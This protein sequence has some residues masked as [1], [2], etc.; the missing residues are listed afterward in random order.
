MKLAWVE[1]FVALVDARTFSRAAMLRNV[2]QPA[3][4]RRIRML[5]DW[6]GVKLVSR[7]TH[8]LRLTDTATRYEPAL[9]RLVNRCHEL[10]GQM[11]AD[12]LAGQRIALVTQHTLMVTHLPKLLGFIHTR[13]PEVGFRLRAANRDECIAQLNRGEAELLLCFETEAEALSDQVPDMQRIVVGS[14]RLVPV[15]APGD[16]QQPLFDPRKDNSL[17]LLGYPE[18]SFLGQAIRTGPLRA[19]AR[20]HTIETVCESAFTV[21]LKEMALAGIGVAWL[22]RALIERE[23]E[24]GALLSLEGALESLDIGIAVYR[25]SDASSNRLDTIWWLLQ[26][27]T[28]AL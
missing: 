12:A 9:R 28:L 22:P 1:D 15:S 27:E 4:S 10:R 11:R 7:G 13:R 18:D 3:F 17:K 21:G 8:Q 5:E 6:L 24:S 26:S 20:A 14:D 16:Y 25:R 2:S 19:T 23:L